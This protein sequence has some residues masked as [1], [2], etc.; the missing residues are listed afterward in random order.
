MAFEAKDGETG[1]F[2]TSSW[3]WYLLHT[4]MVW[5]H[6]CY[7]VRILAV[8][9]TKPPFKACLNQQRNW[10]VHIAV[11]F[12]G[13]DLV[14]TQLASELQCL[15]FSDCLSVS[16]CL[17]FSICCIC[18]P[19]YDLHFSEMNL[20][21]GDKESHQPLQHCI[22]PLAS[23][24]GLRLVLTGLTWTICLCLNQSL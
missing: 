11:K 19:L 18:F 9:I 2:C 15:S 8:Q 1:I 23:A 13:S 14:W 4:A 7:Y 16:L 3:A 22:L 12:K 21:C 20:H 10:I 17:P 24:K 5:V 6:L